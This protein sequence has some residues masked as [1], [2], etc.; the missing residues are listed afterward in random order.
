MYVGGAFSEIGGVARSNLA[1]V[2][3]AGPALVDPNWAPTPNGDIEAMAFGLDNQMFVGGSFTMVSGQ[4]HR[5]LA[6]L[7]TLGE[8]AADASWT[9]DITLSG[10]LIYSLV[11]NGAGN[12]LV[13]GIR[14]SRGTGHASRAAAGNCRC[15]LRRR[16][17]VEPRG[18]PN[19]WR[20][21]APREPMG[22]TPGHSIMHAARPHSGRATQTIHFAARSATAA[23]APSPDADTPRR[24]NREWVTFWS[25]RRQAS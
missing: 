25:Q 8:G 17:R 7:S 23:A 10:S 20:A 14:I 2:S 3:I 15:D 6:K 5:K 24:A 19:A 22:P 11:I 21:R 13:G 16:I 9:P 4:T 1:K 18:W 12:L